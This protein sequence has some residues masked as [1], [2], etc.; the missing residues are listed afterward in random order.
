MLLLLKIANVVLLLEC[1]SRLILALLHFKL[2]IAFGHPGVSGH[3][4]N[5]TEAFTKI[6]R[7][8]FSKVDV[9]VGQPAERCKHIYIYIYIY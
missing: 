1:E 7:T 4:V 3:R 9:N 6:G 5:S 8:N 2:S